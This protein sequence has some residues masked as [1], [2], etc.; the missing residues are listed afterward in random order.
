MTYFRFFA[1]TITIVIVRIAGVDEIKA[2]STG[3]LRGKIVDSRTSKPLP[4]STVTLK[5]NLLGVHSN[6][7]GDFRISESSEFQSD[8][9]IITCI[10]YN[11]YA[12]AYKDLKSK[13]VNLIKLMPFVYKLDEVQIV[14]S[15]NMMAARRMVTKAIR[16]IRS[17]YPRDR[18]SYVAYYRDYQKREDQYLNLNEAIIQVEDNGFQ[19]KSVLNKYR[20]LDFRIN[21]EFPVTMISPYYDTLS[22]PFFGLRNK[23]IEGA[24]LPDQGGNEMFILMVHDAIR[25]FN[26]GSF[27]FV[28]TFSRD[29]LVNHSFTGMSKVFNDDLMLYKISFV[30]NHR[31]TGDS[32]TVYGDI[33]IQPEDFS[34]HKLDYYGGY[35]RK[36]KE[37]K[38]MFNI[39][40]EY[41][42]EAGSKMF[43]R[44]VSFNN[45]FNVIDTNDISYF[46]ILKSYFL[47][48]S[49]IIDFSYPTTLFIEFNNKIDPRT[50]NDTNYYKIII[51]GKSARIKKIDV[52][53]TKVML[54][55]EA[56]ENRSNRT[57]EAEEL[58]PDRLVYV[59]NIRDIN[60]RK[61]DERKFIEY[62]QYRELFVQEYNS[63]MQLGDSCL[64]IDKPLNQNCITGL[65]GDKKYW[66]NSP[67]NIKNDNI[68]LPEDK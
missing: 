46:R 16:N 63:K 37:K 30:T 26:T 1:V 39:K 11:R 6:A 32:L 55:L 34:I 18:F 40:T 59:N 33:Y 41:G 17:N 68:S 24:T 58:S 3:Y 38:E 66:M 5:K 67:T 25:N 65:P 53:E 12:L 42:Y 35:L 27:S 50:A 9:L 4:F 49:P 2:Q 23:F 8:S 56:I 36:G 64:I 57:G 47:T 28:N 31:L 15:K 7:D 43:L 21:S 10:G 61:L 29:F 52:G 54:N 45:T 13:E 51:G 14:A 44:F 22:S 60:G 20:L 62:Y 48:N 19:T